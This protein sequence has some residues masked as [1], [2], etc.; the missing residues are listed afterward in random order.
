MSLF[1]TVAECPRGLLGLAAWTASRQSS[2]LLP[3]QEVQMEQQHLGTLDLGTGKAEMV[4]LC[5]CESI[6][7]R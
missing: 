4:G 5:N 2:I 7:T 3:S 6:T 1:I